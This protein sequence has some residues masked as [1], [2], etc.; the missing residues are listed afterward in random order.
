MYLKHHNYED[1]S[2]LQN[3]LAQKIEVAIT[4]NDSVLQQKLAEVGRQLREEAQRRAIVDTGQLRKTM[5][6][7]EWGSGEVTFEG[8]FDPN[9]PLTRKPDEPFRFKKGISNE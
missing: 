9:K 7:H 4:A 5:A 8:N 2:K 1:L 3:E 6:L